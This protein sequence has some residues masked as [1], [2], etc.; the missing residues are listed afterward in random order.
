[1]NKSKLIATQI[2]MLIKGDNTSRYNWY[3]IANVLKEDGKVFIE[4]PKDIRTIAYYGKKQL[5]KI[6]NKN[7]EC[8]SSKFIDNDKVIKGYIFFI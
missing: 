5:S 7:V 6:L 2:R 4:I 8:I 3:Y 1:M